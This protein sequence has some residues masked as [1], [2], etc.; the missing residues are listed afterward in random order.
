MA[1]PKIFVLHVK[2]GY[3]DREVHMNQLMSS[4]GLDFEYI[5]DGDLDELTPQIKSKYF[6]ED[7]IKIKAHISCAYKHI[8]VYE[9]M[10]RDNIKSALVLEDDIFLSRKFMEVYNRTIEQ[11]C[12]MDR[13]YYVGFEASWLK[14]IPRSRRRKGVVIYSENDIQCTG[15]YYCNLNYANTVLDYVEKVK[16]ATGID[17]YLASI[18]KQGLFDIYWTYPVVATQGS[19]SGVMSS[20]I[21]Q[22]GAT[23]IRQ[24]K[25]ILTMRYKELVYFFK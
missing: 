13:P 10:R 6:I 8:L 11:T 12:M 5:L 16:C 2:K 18:G 22:R 20:S 14:L 15:A 1:L 23:R 25:R 9:R 3:E 24:I 7:K 17:H 4:L 19:H 21:D